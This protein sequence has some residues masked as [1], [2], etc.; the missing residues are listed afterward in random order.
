MA[1]LTL[2]LMELTTFGSLRV[3]YAPSRKAFLS[4]RKSFDARKMAHL[5]SSFSFTTQRRKSLVCISGSSQTESHG[6]ASW[7]NCCMF[8]FICS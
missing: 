6:T 4:W 1:A 7:E 2:Y 3:S 5:T 8:D